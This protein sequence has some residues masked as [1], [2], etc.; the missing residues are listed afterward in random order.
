MGR[1][2]EDHRV[3][4]RWVRRALLK[5]KRKRFWESEAGIAEIF[6]AL[7]IMSDETVTPAQC[8]K[9]ICSVGPVDP[10]GPPAGPAARHCNELQSGESVEG[11]ICT[12]DKD[13]R[14]YNDN[15][16]VY[17]NEHAYLK[18]YL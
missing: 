18:R 9:G 13:C 8:L 1:S 5:G 12:E 14:I 6:A 11:C 3:H 15:Y 4:R 17:F 2:I 7:T 10:Y 16:E